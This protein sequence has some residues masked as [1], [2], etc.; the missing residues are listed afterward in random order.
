ML[1]LTYPLQ[2]LEPSSCRMSGSAKEAEQ[3]SHLRTPETRRAEEG[4]EEVEDMPEASGQQDDFKCMKLA[5]GW[6]N[7]DAWGKAS[8]QSSK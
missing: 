5:N 2:S 8:L 3:L 1:P 6:Q 4:K 7:S